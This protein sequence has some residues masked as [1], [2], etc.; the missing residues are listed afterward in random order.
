M[1]SK[2]IRKSS[3]VLSLLLALIA[4]LFAANVYREA[5]NQKLVFI[6]G[7]AGKFSGQEAK[8]LI[9]LL[10]KYE[11]EWYVANR[12]YAPRVETDEGII[13]PMGI[14]FYL[15]ENLNVTIN[16]TD[17]FSPYEIIKCSAQ[18]VGQRFNLITSNAAEVGA[19][20]VINY[21]NMS[22]NKSA[23]FGIVICENG[24]AYFAAGGLYIDRGLYTF[25]KRNGFHDPIR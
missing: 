20:F 13:D 4:A 9:D 18:E 19:S 12:K 15:N 1:R 23:G 7:L 8:E 3:I 11:G 14:V 21:Q 5:E 2:K 6:Q 10:N 22:D 16:G 24:N 25:S 17:V